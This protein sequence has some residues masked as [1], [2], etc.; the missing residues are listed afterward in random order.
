MNVVLVHLT[1]LVPTS[2]TGTFTVQ[3]GGASRLTIGATTSSAD[4]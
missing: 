2:I 1:E 4:Q 3:H